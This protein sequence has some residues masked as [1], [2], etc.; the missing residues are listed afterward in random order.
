MANVDDMA[1]N[2]GYVYSMKKANTELYAGFVHQEADLGAG[3]Q[4]AV[5]ST[6]VQDINVFGVGARVKFN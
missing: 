3:A 2:A 4:A 5:G 1:I 6:G